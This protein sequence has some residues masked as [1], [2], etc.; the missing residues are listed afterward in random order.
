MLPIIQAPQNPLILWGFFMRADSP[1]RYEIV[2]LDN[3]DAA[4][5]QAEARHLLN[6]ELAFRR[7]HA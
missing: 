6:G 2:P 7:R 3:V 1:G 4:V 5:L